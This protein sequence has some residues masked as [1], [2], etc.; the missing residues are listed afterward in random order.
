MVDH[1]NGFT[2]AAVVKS[3]HKEEIVNAIFQ[4]CIALFG[5]PNQKFSDNGGEFNK[6]LLKE[7]S[8][9][10]NI[11][12][13]STASESPWSNGIK[14]RHY[15]ILGNMISKLLLDESNKYPIE[16]IV[17]WAVSA[18]NVLHNCHGYSPNQLV[19]GKNPNFPSVLIDNPP[20]FEGQTSSEIIA[21]HLNVMHAAQA[22]FI[23]SKASEKR[24]KVIMVKPR[25]AT[26]L[27][28]EPGDNVY[29]KHENSKLWKGT[30]TVIGQEN[31]HILV[32]YGGTYLRVHGCRL[33]QAKDVKPLPECEIEDEKDQT[34]ITTAKIR[35]E[36]YDERNLSTTFSDTIVNEENHQSRDSNSQNIPNEV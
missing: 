16:I 22:A 9:Q 32:K 30:G 19:F 18:K 21:N 5:P 33:Q 23:E 25:T 7:I 6:E 26:P 29:F 1:A 20:T 11:F 8:D 4:Y 14:E 2:S 17:A 36:I 27:I 34:N 24:R 13:R 31:K 28:Y 10:L 15:A 35:N 12:V 3:K